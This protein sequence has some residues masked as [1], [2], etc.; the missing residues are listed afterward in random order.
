MISCNCSGDYINFFCDKCELPAKIE[1]AYAD[2]PLDTYD[3]REM[4][5]LK[6]EIICPKCGVKTS[7]KIALNFPKGFQS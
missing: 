6:L 7:Y 5:I 1:S 4:H 3:I 2:D